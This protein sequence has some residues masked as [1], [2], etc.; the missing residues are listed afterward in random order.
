[1]DSVTWR[2]STRSS[3]NGGDCVEVADLSDAVALR[4]ACERGFA[5]RDIADPFHVFL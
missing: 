1:M 2:R 4:D 5:D 3:S